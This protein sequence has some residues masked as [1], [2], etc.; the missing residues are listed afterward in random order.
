M[1]KAFPALY[2]AFAF[3]LVLGVGPAWAYDCP[4]LYAECQE[5]LKTQKNEEAKQ[6]CEQGIKLHKAGEHDA[7]V[8]KLEAALELIQKQQNK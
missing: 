6:M 3:A 2:L 1:K 4:N 7:A 5:L 8:E